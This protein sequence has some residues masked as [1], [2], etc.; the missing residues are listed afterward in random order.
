MNRMRPAQ[1]DKMTEQILAQIKV[2]QWSALF[3]L[4]VYPVFALSVLL[5]PV[6]LVIALLSILIL[7]AFELRAQTKSK[8]WLRLLCF[9]WLILAVPTYGIMPLLMVQRWHYFLPL[10]RYLGVFTGITL[11]TTYNLFY[12]TP[13]LNGVNHPFPPMSELQI[14]LLGIGV[15]LTSLAPALWLVKHGIRNSR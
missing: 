13:D 7:V 4:L 2:Y 12:A 10:G 6:I 15:L 8:N 5:F 14:Y 1:E 11:T 9:S 3:L